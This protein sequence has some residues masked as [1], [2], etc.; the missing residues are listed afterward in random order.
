VLL[1]Y[2]EQPLP[3]EK[4]VPN[5]QSPTVKVKPGEIL[6]LG[7]LGAGN[8]AM[9]TFLPVI[10]KAGGI[11]PVGIVSASGVNA[12]HA[13]RRFGFGYAASEPEALLEDP[14]I[15]LIAILTRHHLHT[16]QILNAF[17]AGKHVYCEK[18][19]AIKPQE[20]AKIK[21]VLQKKD[22]P[23]LTIGFN[24]RFAPLA[25]H[26][27]AFVDQ[28]HEPLYMHYRVN[29]SVLPAEHWLIDPKVGGGRIIGEG[30]HF[31]DFLTFLVG[32]PPVEVSSQGL[33]DGGKYSEDN[34]SMTFRF[35]DGSLGVVSYL[36]NGDRAFPK[37]YLEVF[38]GGRVAVL[39]D[40]RTL[41]LVARGKRKVKRHWLRQDKGHQQA[42][43][44]FLEAVQGKGT[45]PIPYSQLIAVAQASFAAVDSLRSGEK[46]PISGD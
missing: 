12:H 17:Q 37:E 11:A 5:L 15:N 4:R 45:P 25:T 9:S 20:L 36:A 19:L 46:V 3:K 18:P 38:S 8:Y 6:T 7:V 35:P 23:L 42:W 28:R 43:V 44:S 2:A 40:W 10:K 41:E 33:P 34:V 22:Q 27:K 24:R 31:I 26:L 39:N 13:A 32:E 14:A 21:K 30:C 16:Q 1:T 29:A